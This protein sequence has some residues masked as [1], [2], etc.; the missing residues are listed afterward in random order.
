M[1]PSPAAHSA[2]RSDPRDG[3]RPCRDRLRAGKEGDTGRQGLCDRGRGKGLKE[4]RIRLDI[5]KVLQPGEA[6]H[7]LQGGSDAASPE[8]PGGCEH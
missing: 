2:H 8:T 5:R 7:G 6:P 4:G 1:A 3:M